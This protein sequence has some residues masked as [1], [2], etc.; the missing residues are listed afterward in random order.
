MT[1]GQLKVEDKTNEVTAMPE[2]LDM[3]EVEGMP[4]LDASDSET[5]K[6]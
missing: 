5:E 2:L 1:S 4:I 3:L 6:R